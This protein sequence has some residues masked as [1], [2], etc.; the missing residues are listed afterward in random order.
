MNFQDLIAKNC[1]FFITLKTNNLAGPT[2]GGNLLK[3]TASSRAR[4]RETFATSLQQS[5]NE[6][7]TMPNVSGNHP[8]TWGSC[9]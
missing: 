1:K 6:V 5:K 7:K 3:F 4:K 2:L 9:W 8:I